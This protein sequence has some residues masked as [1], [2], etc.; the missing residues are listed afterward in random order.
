[1]ANKSAS[2]WR[3]LAELAAGKVRLAEQALANSNNVVLHAESKR[4][5][6]R[7]HAASLD[8]GAKQQLVTAQNLCVRQQFRSRLAT[9]LAEQQQEVINCRYQ[10]ASVRKTWVD[11]RLRVQSFEH[12]AEREDSN[13]LEKEGLDERRHLDSIAV[14]SYARGGSDS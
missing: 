6:L 10:Q 13:Q 7:D 3:R 14:I 1:M 5:L 12:L 9:A 4:K 2:R 11:A 8:A